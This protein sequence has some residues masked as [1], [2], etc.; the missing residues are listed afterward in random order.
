MIVKV[1]PPALLVALAF[2]APATAAVD[3]TCYQVSVTLDRVPD[4][5]PWLGYCPRPTR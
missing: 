3:P 4:V 5:A 1:V 2:A